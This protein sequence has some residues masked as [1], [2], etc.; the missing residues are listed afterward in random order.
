MP[1]LWLD[2]RNDRRRRQDSLVV[3]AREVEETAA[4]YGLALALLSSLAIQKREGRLRSLEAFESGGDRLSDRCH[5]MF[6]R[7]VTP[8]IL[9]VGTEVVS[10]RSR[11]NLQRCGAGMLS[12]EVIFGTT[13]FRSPG[14]RQP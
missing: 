14:R 1:T 13:A 12:R 8:P 2:R 11:D 5:S 6:R 3:A 4:N 9:K 7:P 10:R